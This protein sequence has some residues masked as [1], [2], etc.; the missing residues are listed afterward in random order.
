MHHAARKVKSLVLN[1]IR[2]LIGAHFGSSQST[3]KG[4]LFAQK[5]RLGCAPPD[6][7]DR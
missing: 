1:D 6:C 7:T 4:I 2:V 3:R 5:P